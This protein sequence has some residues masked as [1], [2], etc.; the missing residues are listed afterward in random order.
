MGRHQHKK[1]HSS[2][3]DRY[4]KD[5]ISLPAYPH[6]VRINA[7]PM[8]TIY[9]NVDADPEATEEYTAKSWCDPI[10]Q[11]IVSQT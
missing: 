5:Y 11:A 2:M 8:K 4:D 9:I 1:K 3:D 6:I 7:V 10:L